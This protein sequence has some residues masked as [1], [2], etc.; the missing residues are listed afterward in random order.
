M[1]PLA[2]CSPTRLL[3]LPLIVAD[4]TAAAAVAASG[5]AW[6]LQLPLLLLTCTCVIGTIQQS[7]ARADAKIAVLPPA[8]PLTG[9]ACQELSWMAKWMALTRERGPLVVHSDVWL[10]LPYASHWH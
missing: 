10:L 4:A 3:P 7:W 1:A 8:S 9:G 2:L 6:P 5:L